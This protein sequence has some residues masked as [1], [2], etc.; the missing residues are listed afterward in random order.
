MSGTANSKWAFSDE[1][2]H[3]A[4][5]NH[6]AEEL[7]KPTN[8]LDDLIDFLKTIPA[9]KLAQYIFLDA[10]LETNQFKF[11]PVIESNTLCHISNE[12]HLIF[13]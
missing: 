11:A 6:I 9:E 1:K 13:V 3:V 5:A 12:T 10:S 2:D 8:S 7:G 4:L